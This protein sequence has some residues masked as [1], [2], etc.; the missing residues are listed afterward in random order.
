MSTQAECVKVLQTESERLQQY[1]TVLPADAWTQPS[2]CALWD[3]RDVV[4][5]LSGIAQGYTDRITR[6]LRG[7]T[8]PSAGDGK[9]RPLVPRSRCLPRLKP[10]VRL[11]TIISGSSWNRVGDFR[12]VW[13][14]G[15]VKGLG[16]YR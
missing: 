13:V 5:H 8:S 7:D 15:V 2:A 1:L 9:Q 4:A 3:I 11:S 10:G 14:D 16:A 6:G 12:H